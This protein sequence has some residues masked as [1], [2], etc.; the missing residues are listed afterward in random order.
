MIKLSSVFSGYDKTPVLE[1]INADFKKGELCAILGPNGSGKTTALKTICNMID[2]KGEV[3]ISGEDVLKMKRLEISKKISYLAQSRTT[4]QMTVM[5][6]VLHGRFP[7]LSYPRRYK[8]SDIEIA[9]RKMEQMGISHMA[10]CELSSLSGGM[11]QSVYIAMALCQE[12]DFILL[13]EPTTYL[14]ASNSIKVMN[15]LKGLAQSGK[16]IVSVLHDIPLAMKYADKIVI[17]DDGKI[18]MHETPQKVFESGIIDKVFEIQIGK[19][20]NTYYIK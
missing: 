3:K 1:N 14:D 13:D 2:F 9:K 8:K 5:Q 12:T 16:G 18:L 7:H 6:M 11:R 19:I 10:N 20:E 15:I 4:P 17:M